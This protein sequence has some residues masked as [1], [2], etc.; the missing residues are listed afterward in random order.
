MQKFWSIRMFSFGARLAGVLRGLNA[1][2][3]LLRLVSAGV[4]IVKKV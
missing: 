1:D 4:C 3:G 2:K